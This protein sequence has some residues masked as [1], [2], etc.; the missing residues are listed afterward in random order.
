MGSQ[1]WLYRLLTLYFAVRCAADQRRRVAT[2]N[3]QTHFMNLILKKISFHS[4]YSR[5]SVIWLLHPI[6]ITKSM[7]GRAGGGKAAKKAQRVKWAASHSAF[8][9]ESFLPL[10]FV[11]NKP[12]DVSCG[13][14]MVALIISGH[15]VEV[16]IKPNQYN[17]HI[18]FKG[19]KTNMRFI[20]WKSPRFFTW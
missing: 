3:S 1:L 7:E 10:D 15:P 9:L 20:A 16:L 17:V 14:K 19:T 12:L 18:F 5:N 11:S 8:L 13:S 6:Y 4:F 2:T